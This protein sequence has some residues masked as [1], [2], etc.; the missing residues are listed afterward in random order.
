MK[1]AKEESKVA[2]VVMVVAAVCL[3]V[4]V[5][6]LIFAGSR[7]FAIEFGSVVFFALVAAGIGVMAH[8]G[9]MLVK[10]ARRRRREATG[11]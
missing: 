2:D 7:Q 1:P 3:A 10:Y 6:G 9:W 5:V 4:I 8:V 11:R